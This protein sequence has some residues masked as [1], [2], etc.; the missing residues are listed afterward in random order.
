LDSSNYVGFRAP[1]VIPANIIWD[2]PANDG[3]AGQVF[4]TNGAG[5]TY[6]STPVTFDAFGNVTLPTQGQLRLSELAGGNFTG[7]RSPTALGSNIMYTLPLVA[8]LPGQVLSILDAAQ[9]LVWVNQTGGGGGGGGGSGTVT[10]IDIAIS[11]SGT[12]ILPLG[13]PV[14]TAGTVTITVPNADTGV[15]RGVVTNTAQNIG[16]QKTFVNGVW[17]NGENIAETIINGVKV[18][19]TA[20]VS[21]ATAYIAGQ[22]IDGYTLV[23]QDL[24]LIVGQVPA[25]N[26]G[27]Y[28]VNSIG[29]PTRIGP[30]SDG[31]EF[32]VANG[33]TNSN[34]KWKQDSATAYSIIQEQKIIKVVSTTNGTLATAYAAGQ[35]VDGV[36]LAAGNLFLLTAQTPSTDNGLYYVNAAGAPT[37][38]NTTAGQDFYV[39]SGTAGGGKV[40]TNGGSNSFSVPVVAGGTSTSAPASGSIATGDIVKGF[41]NAGTFNFQKVQGEILNLNGAVTPASGVTT[42]TSMSPT[43]SYSNSTHRLDSTHILTVGQTA[44]GATFN[45]EAFT[46]GTNTFVTEVQLIS[47]AF[48]AAGGNMRTFA[49]KIDS[50]R[51]LICGQKPGSTNIATTAILTVNPTTYALS[52]SATT[53]I[54]T[55]LAIAFATA[56]AYGNNL[57]FSFEPG[58]GDVRLYS[59]Q[60]VAGVVANVS[61]E[62][63]PFWTGPG[64]IFVNNFVEWVDAT[65]VAVGCTSLGTNAELYIVPVV[66]N[67]IGIPGAPLILSAAGSG[68]V[69]N[70]YRVQDNKLLVSV[71][72]A[73]GGSGRLCIVDTIG[74]TATNGVFIDPEGANAG[75]MNNYT[76]AGQMYDGTL[77]ASYSNGASTPKATLMTLSGSTLTPRAVSFSI[78]ANTGCSLNYLYPTKMIGLTQIAGVTVTMY[79]IA[80][81]SDDRSSALGIATAGGATPTVT[82]VLGANTSGVVGLT[83]NTKYYIEPDGSIASA[84]TPYLIGTGTSA[85]SLLLKV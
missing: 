30:V 29:V 13:G 54:T 7:F 47:A 44:G 72:L 62:F 19:S 52:L 34:T 24:I 23:D 80:P 40:Y 8:G 50:T 3:T 82:T 6:W 73:A 57:I 60:I 48:E 45:I 51:Y 85:T 25:T 22:V 26:N 31:T 61:L 38:I 12:D 37:K 75:N 1:A 10:S 66:A 46:I 35:V 84:V 67:V 2:L 11:N 32:Y 5:V 79:N 74:T 14:T 36:T 15:T 65:H 20:N 59:A 43:I 16:G 63:R 21:L 71:N 55:P 58:A 77:W 64:F 81:A 68:R 27:Y 28:R 78:T 49:S 18:V 76:S 53:D 83:P 42:I 9:N 39:T 70:I 4:T 33:T 17:L 56:S 69:T 41:N